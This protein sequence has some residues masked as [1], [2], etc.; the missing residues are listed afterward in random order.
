MI[1]DEAYQILTTYL[2]NPNLIKHCLA[3]ETVM[4]ALYR[5]LNPQPYDILLEEKWGITGLLHD[6]DYELSKGNPQTHGL[7]ICEKQPAIPPDIAYA[8]KAHNFENTKIEPV[9]LMDWSIYCAD[10]LTG[11]IVAATLVKP[12]QKLASV[13][14]E[15]VLEKFND[16]SFAKG[17]NREAIK[18][19]EPKLG[20][21]LADFISITLTAMQSISIALGL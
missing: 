15:F 4:K 13:T 17:A 9:S 21:N 18:M 3:A 8:I 20:I 16:N 1:R 5:K 6:A 19:C 10:Q 2:T 7:L 11:L 12:D 14:P